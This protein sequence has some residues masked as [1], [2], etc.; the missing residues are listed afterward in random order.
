MQ[1]ATVTLDSNWDE[2]TLC[3]LLL[4]TSNE[5][6]QKSCFQLLFQDIDIASGSVTAYLMFGRIFRDSITTN[7]ISILP[8]KKFENW[9][10]FDEVITYK[11]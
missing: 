3:F 1:D 6:L 2:E 7:F 5:L 8:V 9:S 10:I 4:I 11:A